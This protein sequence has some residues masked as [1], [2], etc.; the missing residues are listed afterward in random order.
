MKEEKYLYQKLI[1]RNHLKMMIPSDISSAAF[2][3]VMALI[4]KNS[5]IVIKNVTLNETRTGI[6]TILNQM[7][8]NI[9]IENEIEE[10]G[11]KRGDIRVK[12][13]ELKNI[14]YPERINSKYY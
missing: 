3:I 9:V 2:F 4:I 14:K 1:I 6:L 12:S 8:G 7:G 5:E 13:S 10:N 11:E